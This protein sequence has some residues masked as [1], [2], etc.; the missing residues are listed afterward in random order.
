MI[1]VVVYGR[2]RDNAK[3]FRLRGTASTALFSVRS[4]GKVR[5]RPKE[6]R[7]PG[8]KDPVCDTRCD[9]TV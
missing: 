4:Q 7:E 9:T 3:Y 2:K 1:L 5:C 6:Y 8:D